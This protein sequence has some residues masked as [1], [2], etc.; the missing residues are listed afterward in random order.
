MDTTAAISD[1]DFLTTQ[2]WPA[3]TE[4]N[5]A[6]WGILYERRMNQLRHNGSRLFL[7]G[8]DAIAL[9]RDRVPDLDD[10]NG[11]LG[12]RTG[13]NAV[14]VKGFIPAHDFFRCLSE[15]RF[16]TTVIV[17]SREQLDYLPEPDI[18]HDVFGHVPLH[19]DAVFADFLQRFGAV[20][21]RARTD[22]ET[23]QMARLFWFTV[24]FGLIREAGDV[25]VYGSGLISSH[26][27]AANALGPKCDR[28]PFSL[29][30]VI[31][32]AFEIDH[33]QDVLFVVDAFDQLFDAVRAMDQRMN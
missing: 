1:S 10:V 28:R 21:V 11:R 5:H 22:E 30:A 26:G 17:R 12:P 25:K 4:E 9:R 27:D 31:S 6:V 18:F 8:A 20:A 29:D 3:Y 23:A 19:A 24:E 32:Q 15:R 14:P 7:E 33:F 2:A 16:P 13:W